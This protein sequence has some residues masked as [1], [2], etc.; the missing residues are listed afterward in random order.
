MVRTIDGEKKF[1]I[2]ADEC[3]CETTT[4]GPTTTTALPP[5]EECPTDAYCLAQYEDTYYV[6]DIVATNCRWPGDSGPIDCSGSYV[7]TRLTADCGWINQ[8]CIEAHLWEC[9]VTLTCSSGYWW[10]RVRVCYSFAPYGCVWRK[11]LETGPT[12]NYSYF[13]P[14]PLYCSATVT[15]YS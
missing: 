11:A 2:D 10:V 15:I 12:G 7:L 1:I 6:D 14:N 5:L 3:C 9:I 8:T 13:S 4:A